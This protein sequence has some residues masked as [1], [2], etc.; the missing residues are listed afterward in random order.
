MK[1]HKVREKIENI[2]ENPASMFYRR[3]T[4]S[5]LFSLIITFLYYLGII[6]NVKS[7]LDSIVT[8]ASI[9][10]AVIAMVLTIITAVRDGKAYK[11][12][13]ESNKKL[14]KEFYVYVRHGVLYGITTILIAIGVKIFVI[15]SMIAKISFSLVGSFLFSMMICN[16]LIAFIVSFQIMEID[17]TTL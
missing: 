11:K 2:Y 17:D 9:V 16:T 7:V 1:K 8:F 4:I 13:Q 5:I 15:N 10:L 14:L 3:K 12:L 6:N